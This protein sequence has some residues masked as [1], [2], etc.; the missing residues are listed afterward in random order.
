M[1][2]IVSVL[3]AAHLDVKRGAK[4]VLKDVNWIVEP[5]D[6]WVLFG[7]NGSGKTT[8]LS[9][10][11]GYL[12]QTQ[13]EIALC[14]ETPNAEN[15]CSLRQKI[16]WAS[17]SFFDRYYSSESIMDIVLAGKTGSLCCNYEMISDADI[18]KAKS[19]L[20]YLGLGHNSRYMY[21]MLS[22]GQRQKVLVARALIT[23]AEVLILDEPCNGM[24]ILSREKLLCELGHILDE[25]N[26]ALVYVTHHPDEIV[27]FFN[28]ALVLRNGKVF[29]KGQLHD[30]FSNDVLQDYFDVPA[31]I[32][33]D[34][35]NL[36]IHL[37]FDKKSIRNQFII[38]GLE[39]AD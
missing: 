18:R 10:L 1:V 25:T 2:N 3:N 11:S 21:D 31:E 5:G 35:D 12:S 14:G 22:Q 33:W 20:S 6:R 13:G 27:S 26:I 38:D 8:L 39:M 17:T 7:S 24:D 15:I 37:D 4:F 29:A 28:K 16:G 32:S 34:K 30:I 23:E 19:I 9:I 36:S